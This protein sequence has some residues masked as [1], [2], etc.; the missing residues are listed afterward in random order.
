VDCGYTIT[1]AETPV[2]HFVDIFFKSVDNVDEVGY[3]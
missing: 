3:T 1:R 2:N